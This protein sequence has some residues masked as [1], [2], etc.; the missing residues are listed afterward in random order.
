M[1]RY[2]RTAFAAAV[3]AAT[4]A[5]VPTVA[6]AED[7]GSSTFIKV[8]Y[9]GEQSVSGGCSHTELWGTLASKG[10]PEYRWGNYLAC[11]APLNKTNISEWKDGVGDHLD[12]VQAFAEV[13]EAAGAVYSEDIETVSKL[14][15]FM[16]EGPNK[17]ATV[18][19]RSRIYHVDLVKV[20]ADGSKVV[21]DHAEATF[22]DRPRFKWLTP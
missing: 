7:D 5:S 18:T 14:P 3:L 17:S 21:I 10:S 22:E 13:R 16:P 19:K 20:N 15:Y 12:H 8:T 1:K 11:F 2:R 4:A 9:M 6:H